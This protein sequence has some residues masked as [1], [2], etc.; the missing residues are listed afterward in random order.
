MAK[1]SDEQQ[2]TKFGRNDRIVFE[3]SALKVGRHPN[4]SVK[5]ARKRY[6]KAITA[7]VYDTL[8]DASIIGFGVSFWIDNKGKAAAR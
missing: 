5:A 6:D 3:F 7:F 1:I 2:I 8:T 4:E